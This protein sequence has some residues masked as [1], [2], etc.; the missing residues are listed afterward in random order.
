M[1]LNSELR[2]TGFF[3]LWAAESTSLI[4]SQVTLFALPLVAVLT[5]DAGAWEMGL[6]AAAGSLAVLFFGL[7]AGVWADQYERRN[8][9]RLANLVRAV[10]LLLV[11]VLYWLDSLSVWVLFA[12]AF[13]VGAM[14]LLF[15]SALSSYV[16]RLVGRSSLT[17]ANSWLQ[18]TEAVGEVGGPGV[19]GLLV[20]VLGAPVTILVDS[21]TYLVSTATLST[22]PKA[23]PKEVAPEDRTGHFRAALRGVSL[24][25]RNDIL[26]PLALSAAHFN[27]FTAMF[28]AV[29]VLYVVKVLGFSPLLLGVCTALGGVGGLAAS[30]LVG[31]ISRRT[32]LG[33]MLIACY[34]LPGAAGLLVPAAEGAST[35]VAVALVGGSSLFW[36]FCVVLLLVSGMTIRQALVDDAY[37]GRTTATFR[38]LTWGVEPIGAIAGGALAAG[39]L[40]MR[41]TLVVASA[42]IALSTTWTALSGVRRFHRVPEHDESDRPDA[43]VSR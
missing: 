28:F 40:G 13:V 7:S 1:S 35:W 31:P 19:A 3:R 6:L 15:E 2:R 20:Q 23:P 42:G 39:P 41:A 38:F 8:V 34:A 4:G 43:E 12:V 26:R 33:R 24:V 22:L 5:L 37:L 9:M 30:T 16:P 29:Y 14:T 21:I 11:P 18:G 36:S 17:Q 25:W 27:L 32:G 10:T